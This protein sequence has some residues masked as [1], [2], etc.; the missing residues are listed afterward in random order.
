MRK[1]IAEST[2]PYRHHYK[3]VSLWVVGQTNNGRANGYLEWFRKHGT[4]LRFGHFKND[5]QVNEW[6][7]HDKLGKISK[8]PTIETETTSRH[9]PLTVSGLPR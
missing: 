2:E 8:V 4:K 3:D 1:H 7:T 6:T 9:I 5:M